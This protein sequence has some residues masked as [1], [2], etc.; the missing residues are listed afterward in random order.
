MAEQ[1]H[2]AL[3]SFFRLNWQDFTTFWILSL[4]VITTGHINNIMA[5]KISYVKFLFYMLVIA[6]TYIILNVCAYIGLL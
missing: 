1:Y 3:L 4:W 2:D 6:K 5:G